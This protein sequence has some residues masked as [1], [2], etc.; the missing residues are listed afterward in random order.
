MSLIWQGPTEEQYLA[1]EASDRRCE[2][3]LWFIAAILIILVIEIG[4]AL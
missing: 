1:A 4:L 3:A 2:I